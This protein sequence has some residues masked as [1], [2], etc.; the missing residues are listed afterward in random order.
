MTGICGG[1]KDKN[2]I[3]DLVF[4]DAAIDWDYGKWSDEKLTSG[5]YLL[6]FFLFAPRP[7]V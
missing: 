7:L 4:A 2:N 1:V 5:G 3:G 6:Y